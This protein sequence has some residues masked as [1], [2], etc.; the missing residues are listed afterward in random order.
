M[1]RKHSGAFLVAALSAIVGHADLIRFNFTGAA[2]N[3]A[4]TAA[5]LIDPNVTATDLVRGS[6]LT[7][8]TTTNSINSSAWT[9]GSAI[10]VNDYYGFSL[11]PTAGNVMT[12]TGISFG[13][14]RSLTGIRTF[15]LRSSMDNFTAAIAG[16]VTSIPDDVSIRNQTIA[17]G[18]VFANLPA[19]VSF[20]IYGYNAEGGTGTWR[21]QNHP[22]FSGLLVDGTTSAASA[23]VPEPA[24]ALACLGLIGSWVLGSWR[25]RRL[26]HSIAR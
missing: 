9:T 11:A 19:S 23:A 17:V 5:T 12:I 14:R 13:E 6:G 25:L 10:D 2:G 21:L 8:E 4:S 20:R 22:S 3:Q 15:E 16:S 7:P 1:S 26:G 24:T 18:A